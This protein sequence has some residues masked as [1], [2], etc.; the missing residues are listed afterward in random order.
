MQQ[1]LNFNY[2]HLQL[3]HCHLSTLTAT[4]NMLASSQF[5]FLFNKIHFIEH[6]EN[7]KYLTHFLLLG[8]VLEY[9]FVLFWKI[10]GP[11]LRPGGKWHCSG[12]PFMVP[13]A[14]K[15]KLCGTKHCQLPQ[16]YT[17]SVIYY[18]NF[19]LPSS[20]NQ[21]VKCQPLH[22]NNTEHVSVRSLTISQL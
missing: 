14:A 3:N 4:I 6:I 19:Q 16:H 7:F 17:K 18:S 20:F 11:K 21:I 13:T 15:D 10:S 8:P 9:D 5:Q 1:I 12:K 22:E 2:I